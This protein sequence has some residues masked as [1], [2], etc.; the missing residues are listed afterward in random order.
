MA[1]QD[2]LDSVTNLANFPLLTALIERR[3]R[4]FGKGMTMHKGPLQY[5]SA[6]EPEPLTREEE[7][8]L[9]FAACGVT[10]Y[11][12][13]ELPYD[14]DKDPNEGGGNI[15]VHF[16]GRTAASG[17]AIHSVSVFV[18]NDHEVRLLKRPQDFPRS[19]IHALITAANQRQLGEVYERSSVILGNERVELPRHMPYVAPFNTWDT[20]VKGTTYFVPVIEYTTLYLNVLLSALSP[21]IGMF[22]VDE[23]HNF[24]PAGLAKF[25]KSNGGFLKDDSANTGTV[26]LVENALGA[27]TGVELGM[28]LQNLALMTEALGL[29]GYTH[30][31]AH[32]E[33]LK[34]LG[35]D[36]QQ[37]PFSRVMGLGPLKSALVRLMGKDIGVPTAVGLQ[38]NGTPLLRPFC[39]PHYRNMEE[40]VLAYVDYK[41][42]KSGTYRDGGTATGWQHPKAVQEE[43]PPYPEKTIAATIAYCD[44]IYSRYGRF[45]ALTGPFGNLLAYQAHHLDL[46]FYDKYYRSDALSETQ[47]MHTHKNAHSAGS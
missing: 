38:K 30:Q 46:S 32:P 4:R 45:P 6:Q 10:G 34:T 21:D 31:A 19:D 25:A 39:P 28:I 23:R 16:V 14:K 33:W 40:A 24:Q 12:L 29:G 15:V 35:F 5:S 13:A 20:N 1:H 44:Y 18:I 37:V 36:V 42:G 2:S 3:S 11:A 8:A 7:A 27:L 17:D 26:G 43:I 9:A 41:F 22:I 47:R